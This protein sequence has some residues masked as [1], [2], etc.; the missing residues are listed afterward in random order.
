MKGIGVG[1]RAINE[2]ISDSKRRSRERRD[3]EAELNASLDKS[4]RKINQDVKWINRML[5]LIAITS[6]AAYSLM[7]Y[8][9]LTTLH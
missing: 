3:L 1:E 2:A 6:L 9:F 7:I 5:G 4:I 8:S